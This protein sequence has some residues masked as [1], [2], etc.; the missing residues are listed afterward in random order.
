MRKGYILI[1]TVNGKTYKYANI[2]PKYNK[3]LSGNFYLYGDS[4]GDSFGRQTGD[5]GRILR[6]FEKLNYSWT[7]TK[8]GDSVAYIRW[9]EM[10]DTWTL[11]RNT[12]T[13]SKEYSFETQSKPYWGDTRVTRSNASFRLR[14]SAEAIQS[15]TA[16]DEPFIGDTWTNKY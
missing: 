13:T 4:M 12:N 6:D 1:E 14:L 9:P 3:G 15:I 8:T 2:S 5:T 11:V 7:H 16:I 10:G